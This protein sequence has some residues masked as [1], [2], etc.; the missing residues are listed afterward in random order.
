MASRETK[1][2]VEIVPSCVDPKAYR[3]RQHR[4]G[5]VLTAGWVGSGS[6]A[7][8]LQEILPAM[9]RINRDRVEVKLLVVGGDLDYQAPWLEVKPW[10][11]E[12]LADDLDEMDI[13]LMPMPQTEW[14]RGKCGYKLLQYFAAGIPAVASPVGVA[15]RL[16]DGGRGFAATTTEEWVRG[17]RELA[18]NP[19][20]RTEMGANG[21]ATVER[22]YSHERWAPEL[23]RAFKDLI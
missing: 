2:R 14:A 17:I 23:A 22:D 13:G 9:E 3:I 18:G 20:L 11:L 16:L 5:E 8:Y 21:R 4:Q 10:R 1:G 6:T 19:E 15:N 12:K 7:P